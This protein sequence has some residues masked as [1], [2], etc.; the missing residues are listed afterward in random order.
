M[1]TPQPTREEIRDRYESELEAIAEGWLN[2]GDMN[3]DG[4]GGIWASYD[5][6]HGEW[7]VYETT[8]SAMVGWEDAGEEDSGDQYVSHG[9]VQWRDLVTEDGEWTETAQREADSLHRGHDTPM[10]AVVDGDLSAFAAH[11]VAFRGPMDAR[12]GRVQKDSY[13][14]V[15]DSL[16]IEPHDSDNSKYD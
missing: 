15:L 8:L 6:D 4:H 11:F 5:P 12:P 2:Y 9:Y 16:G 13:A 7:E 10:G 14:D 1:Q 3:P